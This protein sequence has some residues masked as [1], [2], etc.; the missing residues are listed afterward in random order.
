MSATANDTKNAD[1][2]LSIV[3]PCYRSEKTIGK[4]VRMTREV[5]LGLGY[6]PEFVLV[7]DCSPDG[8]FAEIVKLRD[9]LPHIVGVDFA[10]NFGQH[11]AIL[12][13][14]RHV[15]GS[16]V[17][18][19]DDDMQT[20]PS[21]C[22]TLLNALT[23]DLDVVFGEYE[24]RKQAWWRRLGSEFNVWTKRV[25]AHY[26]KDIVPS[27]FMVMRRYVADAIAA[28][29]APYP[30]TLGLIFRAT[31][32]VGNVSVK[33]FDREVGKSGY[34]FKSLVKLWSN[35]INFSL[36]PL[37]VATITGAIMGGVG[38]LFALYIL[39]RKLLNPAIQMGWSSL[40]VTILV[41]SGLTILFLGIVGEYVGR[42]F[43]TIND[44]PQ[45]V[46]RNTVRSEDPR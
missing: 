46:I 18:I 33:H 21:Q 23:P 6:E 16:L 3:I 4:L 17:M 25:L 31:S 20:H 39:I 29:G 9:E 19:M 43:M 45:F 30:L 38:L 7:N 26:P 5:L 40:M 11:A 27:N 15:S 13:G 35:V 12:A 10:K 8:T 42:I 2:V 14:M 41:C 36:V 32:K 28:Y 24:H 22:E 37:R 44:V 34:T 1:N